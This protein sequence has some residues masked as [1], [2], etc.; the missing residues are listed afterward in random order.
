[1]RKHFLD[2]RGAPAASS[3]KPLQHES[4]ADCGFLDKEAVDIELVIVFGIGDRR[5]QNLP[6]IARYAAP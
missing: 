2:P 1:M 6:D 5:L 4:S 3:V